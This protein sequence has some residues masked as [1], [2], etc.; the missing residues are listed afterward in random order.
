M[1]YELIIDDGM[2]KPIIA[3]LKQLDFVIVKP[4]KQKVKS[5]D[6]KPSN[7]NVE[8]R[9]FGLCPDWEPDTK[10]IRAN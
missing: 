10:T 6:L 3:L 7:K 4:K 2:E 8:I 5:K 1:T 9:Y